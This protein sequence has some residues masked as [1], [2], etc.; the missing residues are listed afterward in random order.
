MRMSSLVLALAFFTPMMSLAVAEEIIDEEK[1]IEKIAL[2]GGK[3]SR[4]D[5][6]NRTV[7]GVNFKGNK[8]FNY[9]YLNL[10]K[11]FRDLTWLDVSGTTITNAGMP[12][13]G[14][15]TSLTALYLSKSQI[16]DAGLSELRSLKN[17]TT[18]HIVGNGI[19]NEGMRSIGELDE[20]RILHLG[21][22]TITEEGLHELKKLTHLSD[23]NLIHSNLNDDA[24]NVLSELTSLTTLHLGR[25]EISDVGLASFNKLNNL[26]I[27]TYQRNKTTLA[28]EEA[29]K[30]AL[31]NLMMSSVAVKV[32]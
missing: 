15:L 10:L 24:A 27:L 21:R 23:L 20:L 19:S 4:A 6:P 8:K 1:A 2:L 3:I 13:I 11:P 25:N 28:G 30:Q 14:K 7:I 5:T 17:L 18:L 31:P 16:S 32:D 29:L 9:K 26:T 22:T 12:E